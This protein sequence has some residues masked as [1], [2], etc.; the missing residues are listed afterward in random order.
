MRALGQFP[1]GG[2]FLSRVG[3]GLPCPRGT[4]RVQ[5]V[6]GGRSWVFTRGWKSGTLNI[7]DNT[8]QTF[9]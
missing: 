1:V 3:R 8:T 7:H 9:T 4:G 2:M 5:S 6:P